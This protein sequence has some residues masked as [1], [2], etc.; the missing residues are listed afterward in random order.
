VTKPSGS[1]LH[2]S[3]Y[4]Y[5]G[6][7]WDSLADLTKLTPKTTGVTDS[8]NLGMQQ[9]PSKF[10]VHFSG[11][12]SIPANGDYTFTV[13]SD[14]G[15][16]LFLGTYL[17]VNNDKHQVMSTSNS[18]AAIT[19][20]TGCYAIS[21]D[22]YMDSTLVSNSLR[23]GLSV[24]ISSAALAKNKI[25]KS[26]L[27]SEPVSV[28][29]FASADHNFSGPLTYTMANG[30]LIVTV[31]FA[32]AHR[33]EIVKLNGSIAM[34]YNGERESVYRI[35]RNSLPPGSYLIQASN[36]AGTKTVKLLTFY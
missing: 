34:Q 31:G 5:S 33:L 6:K 14:A 17:V 35:T 3:Y 13:N 18:S 2:Y 36:A 7:A 1:G 27:F 25:T 9:R 24:Y 8:F 29:R 28:L 21:L 32:G 26:M 4:E 11:A 30:N 22:Y 19:L 20:K 12:I 15:A 23:P 16:K 10:A